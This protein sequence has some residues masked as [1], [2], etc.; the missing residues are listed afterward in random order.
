MISISKF[1]YENIIFSSNDIYYN[2][3]KWVNS[4]DGK[5]CITGY[6]GSGKTTL[7]KQLAKKYNIQL[8]ELDSYIN[9]N[10][11]DNDYVKELKKN[12][13]FDK[14]Q[15]YY[16]KLIE[17]TINN[18]VNNRHKL[19]IEGIQ[20]FLYSD[21]KKF[22]NHSVI[23]CGT[24]TIVSFFRAYKRNR[25]ED[26]SKNWNTLDLLLDIYHNTFIT[27]VENFIRTVKSWIK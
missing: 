3:D 13:Q 25:K 11:K 6:T 5:L 8:I 24:S 19:I 1:F 23:V 20:L 15:D 7:A 14:L 10:D 9:E 2:F 18:V 21:T 27:K 16:Q 4:K 26:W 12:K 22:K 17:T